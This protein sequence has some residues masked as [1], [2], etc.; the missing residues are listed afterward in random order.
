MQ[1]FL[2]LPLQASSHAAEIDRIIVIVHWL[3]LV[4]FVGWG[5]FFTYTLVRFRQSA[6]PKADYHGVKSHVSSYLEVA[7]GVIEAVILVAFALPAW[8]TR[9]NDVPPESGATVVHVIAKQFAW[10]SVYPGPDGRFGRRDGSLVTPTNEIGLDREDPNGADDIYTINQLNLPV[11]TPVIAY[12]TSMDVIHSFA[13][14]EMR[15]KQDAIPGMEIPIWWEPTVTGA[16]EINCSQLCG[17]GHYR[18]RGAVSVLTQA[19]FRSFLAEE[20]ARLT[21]D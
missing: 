20:G 11:D 18:M 2:G 3:M 12:L 4:L 19:D 8:A 13:I 5:S 15:V 1:E 7:V 9:V 21:A 16:F 14:A 6:N 17:L 10:H